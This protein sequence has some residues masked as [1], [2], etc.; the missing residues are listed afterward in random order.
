[1]CSMESNKNAGCVFYG[2]KSAEVREKCIRG[3]RVFASKKVQSG[4]KIEPSI[5]NH[6]IMTEIDL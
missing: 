4:G 1:M 3:A 2:L 6:N 5:F